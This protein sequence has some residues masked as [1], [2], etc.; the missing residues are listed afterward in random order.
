[1]SAAIDCTLPIGCHVRIIIDLSMLAEA[2]K[3]D[4]EQSMRG[5]VTT[6]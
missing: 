4:I 6:R 2:R 5:T 1:M 3:N